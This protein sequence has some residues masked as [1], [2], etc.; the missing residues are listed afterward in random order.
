M[1]DYLW[2]FIHYK[3]D[4]WTKFILIA[5]FIYYNIN[6]INTKYISFE[7]NCGYYLSIFYIKNIY[8]YPLFKSVGE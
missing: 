2:A 3:K 7:L 1:N 6:N 5:E 4:E 8:S